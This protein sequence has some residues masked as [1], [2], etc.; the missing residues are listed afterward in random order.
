[1]PLTPENPQPQKGR[2]MGE[3]TSSAA[4]ENYNRALRS[5]RSWYQRQNS[6]CGLGRAAQRCVVRPWTRGQAA[7]PDCDADI[8]MMCDG[9]G[10]FFSLECR[11]YCWDNKALLGEAYKEIGLFGLC[12]V[13]LWFILVVCFGFVFFFFFWYLPKGS[14]NWWQKAKATALT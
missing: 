12:F 10:G 14:T 5:V 4:W 3:H 2:E 1:M 7:G 6:A 13:S 11:S 9:T 8:E